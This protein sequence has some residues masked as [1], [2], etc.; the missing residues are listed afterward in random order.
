MSVDSPSAAYNEMLDRWQ[1]C[2]DCVEGTHAIKANG[3][4]YLPALEGHDPRHP[5]DDYWKYVKRALFFAGTGRTI[6]GLV[7]M[8][9]RRPPIVEAPEGSEDLLSD[10]D[11]MGRSLE[12][13]AKALLRE[14]LTVGRAAVLVDHTRPPAEPRPYMRLYRAEEILDVIEDVSGGAVVP[15]QARLREVFEQPSGKTEFDTEVVEQIRVLEIVE[16]RYRQRLFRRINTDTPMATPMAEVE[17]IEPT[18]DT[19]PISTMPLWVFSVDEGGRPKAIEPPPL[20][21]LAE[22][23][24]CHYR[25]EA[26]YRNALHMAG[27]PTMAISGMEKPENPIKV[28]TAEAM[29]MPPP[30]SKAYYVSYGA[31]GAAGDPPEPR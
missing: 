19:D 16:G 18:I 30:D 7:G 28:G 29:W 15:I 13:F 8:V 1:T 3:T 9:F 31:E 4:R 20:I 12:E 26:D 2:R 17:V 10:V 21:D 27:V 25:Q 6:Q 11:L 5:N 23:N 14:L 24:L 22:V